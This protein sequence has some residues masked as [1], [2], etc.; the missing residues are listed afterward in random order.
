MKLFDSLENHMRLIASKHNLLTQESGKTVEDIEK[1]L[2]QLQ[3]KIDELRNRP[4]TVE[5]YSANPLHPRKLLESDYCYLS[6]PR[7][8]ILPNGV[9][10]IMFSTDWSDMDRENFLHDMRANVIKKATK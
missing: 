5:A 6:K 7:I 2:I 8:E 10:R 9:I 3:S 1:K 4:T